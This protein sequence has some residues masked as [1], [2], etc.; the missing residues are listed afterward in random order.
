MNE[1]RYPVSTT[2]HIS[3]ILP[4]HG[5]INIEYLQIVNGREGLLE[6][7]GGLQK[8]GYAHV[9]LQCLINIFVCIMVRKELKSKKT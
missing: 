3:P 6:W 2:D 5:H 4:S 7:V 1:I 8:N 9:I